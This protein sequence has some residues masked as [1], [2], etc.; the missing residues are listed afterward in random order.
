MLTSA[1][2]AG[3]STRD[4]KGLKTLIPCCAAVKDIIS[5]AGV[6]F[7]VCEPYHE[8]V[9]VQGVLGLGCFAYQASA[10]HCRA[11]RQLQKAVAALCLRQAGKGLVWF[12][13]V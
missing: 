4:R 9:L 8:P 13:G 7:G 2:V 12:M 1:V 10:L 11:T 6:R 5:S 3:E